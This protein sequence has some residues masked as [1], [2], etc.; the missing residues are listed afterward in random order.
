M[1]QPNRP[2]PDARPA[3]ADRSSTRSPIV[4]LDPSRQ[5]VRSLDCQTSPP[6]WLRSLL[7]LQRGATLVFGIV[8]GL[9]AIGYG[10]TV[11][12][13]DVWKQQH[14]QLKRLQVQER[15]QGAITESIK[16][17][18]AIAA[19]RPQNELIPPDP[20]QMLFVPSAPLRPLKPVPATSSAKTSSTS[21]PPSGY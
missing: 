11:Y 17:Q 18:L 4:E 6:V 16:H 2:L 19:D 14:G 15:Q 13:Q 1:S 12:T 7:T 3:I 9:S 8:F 10:Y 21:Q 20:K 5:R